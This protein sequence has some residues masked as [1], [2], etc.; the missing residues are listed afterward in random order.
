M[1]EAEKS[2]RKLGKKRTALLQK[3]VCDEELMVSTST[4]DRGNDTSTVTIF[5]V[6]FSCARVEENPLSV[7]QRG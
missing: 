4:T 7:S 1:Q 2:L 6:L 5:Y 3:S